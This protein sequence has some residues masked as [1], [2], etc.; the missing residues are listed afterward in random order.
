[1]TDT[2]KIEIEPL[3]AQAFAPFGLLLEP[4]W[5]ATFDL[6]EKNLHR[7]P[8]QADSP[9]I[10]QILEFKPQPMIVRKI[11]RHTHVTES[12]MHIGGS[13]TIIVVAAPSDA[14]PRATDLRAFR[15]EGQGVMFKAGTWHAV[16]AFPEGEEPGFFLFLSDRETQRELFDD[17]VQHPTRSAFHDYVAGGQDVRIS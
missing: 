3:T 9:V 8:W 14:P 15:L 11:E 16:D 6:P 1:M 10:V 4:T 12:R 17:P 2:V 5:P 13:S 7:F